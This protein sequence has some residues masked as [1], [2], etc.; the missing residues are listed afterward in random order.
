[1]RKKE[2]FEAVAPTFLKVTPGWIAVAL[3]PSS[4]LIL[5]M[6]THVICELLSSVQDLCVNGLV[7]TRAFWKKRLMERGGRCEDS[8][9][10]PGPSPR[11]IR[12]VIESE[13]QWFT[14]LAAAH[15]GSA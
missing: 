5:K 11:S 10:F 12:L 1:M 15:L 14:G 7:L 9:P 6:K 13:T 4:P 2:Q 3:D 8:A